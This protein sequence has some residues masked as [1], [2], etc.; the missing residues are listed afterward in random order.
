MNSSFTE[1]LSDENKIIFL[2]VL[3]FVLGSGKALN[4]EQNALLKAQAAE[5]GLSEAD[6][7]RIKKIKRSE[8]A[9]NAL[10]RVRDVRLRRYFI[11]EIIMLAIAD[12]E[13][14]DSEMCNI[15]K[16]GCAVGIKED[17]I[18]DFFLWAAQGVEWQLEGIRMVEDDL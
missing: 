14:A 5:L 6:V 18:N 10:L 9:A 8:T 16:I 12:H 15:Y 3:A 2:E 4:P 17:K 1:N 11:R 13:L 7:K